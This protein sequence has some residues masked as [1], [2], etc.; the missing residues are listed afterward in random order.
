MAKKEKGR[1]DQIGTP[2]KATVAPVRRNGKELEGKPQSQ[3]DGPASLKPIRLAVSAVNRERTASIRE[4]DSIGRSGRTI[5]RRA[6]T[7]GW[8]R[9]H[10]G[11]KIIRMKYG[12][13]EGGAR[14]GTTD[15]TDRWGYEERTARVDVVSAKAAGD[16]PF[17]LS[18]G[19]LVQQVG[20]GC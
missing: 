5:G 6:I 17:Y 20:E 2:Q 8:R 9:V 11:C 14:A 3:T 10:Q 7:V 18:H 1:P 12:R 19:T 16:I 15:K 4:R 13:I